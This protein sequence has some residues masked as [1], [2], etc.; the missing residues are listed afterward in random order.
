MKKLLQRRQ[1]F[2]LIELLIVIVIIGILAVGFAPTLLNAPKKA[3]DGVRKG[4]IASIQQAVEA[5]ALD[6]STASYP[7]ADA[8]GCVNATALKPY[9]QG[10]IAPVDPSGNTY[11]NGAC[12]TKGSFAYGLDT[13]N[14]CYYIAAT[15]EVPENNNGKGVTAA[16]PCA[17]DTAAKTNFYQV[18]NY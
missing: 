11:Q 16:T 7:A 3:R 18:V 1:G 8:Q 4:Q 2:T 17:I 13:T 5:Y 12:T 14:K 10:G 9:F 6:S 15:M